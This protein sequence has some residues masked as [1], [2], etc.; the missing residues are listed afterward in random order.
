MPNDRS[1]PMS[2][3]R[4]RSVNLLHVRRTPGTQV[5]ATRSII[6]VWRQTNLL[7]R[8]WRWILWK[9][10]LDS[11]FTKTNAVDNGKLN[12]QNEREGIKNDKHADFYGMV[13]MVIW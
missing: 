9:K 13:K 6:S 5:E 4:Q 1:Q 10:N 3:V 2:G 8:L 11:M 7:F 12:F